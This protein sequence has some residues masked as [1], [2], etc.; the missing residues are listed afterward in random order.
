M[1]IHRRTFGVTPCQIRVQKFTDNATPDGATSWLAEAWFDKGGGAPVRG[2]DKKPIRRE[3][4]TSEQEA[5]QKMEDCLIE[6]FGQP[7]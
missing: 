2:A 3:S 4:S 5:L 6:R 7:V 1:E